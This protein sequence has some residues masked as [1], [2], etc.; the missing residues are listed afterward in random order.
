MISC[1]RVNYV[2][3]CIYEGVD[4]KVEMFKVEKIFD[5]IIKASD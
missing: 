4:S 3:E 2:S 1:K 5:L